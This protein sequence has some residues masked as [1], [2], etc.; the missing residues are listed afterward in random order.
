MTQEDVPA[1]WTTPED[2]RVVRK[3][4]IRILP[5]SAFVFFLCSLDRSNIGV[6]TVLCLQ[7]TK[8]TRVSCIG[9]A[10][11][12]NREKGHDLLTQTNITN[13]QYTCVLPCCYC[14]AT[15]SSCRI[16]LMMFSVGYGLFEVPSNILLKRMRPS[17]GVSLFS[18]ECY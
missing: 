4:D 9:A 2:K 1:R 15:D 5:L 13:Y 11:I 10:K 6:Q 7:E 12:M 17:V 18:V 16:A 14:V 3:L 8:L